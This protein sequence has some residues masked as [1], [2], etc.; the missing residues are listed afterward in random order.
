MGHP[1]H[2]LSQGRRRNVAGVEEEGEGREEEE[3]E[4]KKDE[5]ERALNICQWLFEVH[6]V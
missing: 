1:V 6:S 2:F 4:K 3:K 5:C